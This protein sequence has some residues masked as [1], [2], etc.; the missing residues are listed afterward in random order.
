[1]GVN[2]SSKAKASIS[3]KE[4]IDPIEPTAQAKGFILYTRIDNGGFDSGRRI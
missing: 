3:W 1:M 4:T 2:F